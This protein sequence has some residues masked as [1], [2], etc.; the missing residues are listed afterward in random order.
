MFEIYDQ[1]GNVVKR[2]YSKSVDVSNLPKGSYYLNFD[3]T[4]AEFT[5][6]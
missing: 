6:K 3:N 2:G 5:K 1:Y 4:M